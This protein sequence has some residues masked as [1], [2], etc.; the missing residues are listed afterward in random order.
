MRWRDESVKQAIYAAHKFCA[1]GQACSSQP[2]TCLAIGLIVT[3]LLLERF[4]IL[5]RGSNGDFQRGS[6]WNPVSSM[7]I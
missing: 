3:S 4:Q 2:D 6:E 5:Y 1:H 7:A